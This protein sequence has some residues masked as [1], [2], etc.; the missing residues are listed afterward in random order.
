MDKLSP[1]DN[2]KLLN[3]VVYSCETK[4]PQSFQTFAFYLISWPLYC[5]IP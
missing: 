1:K 4:D 2:N 3:L 5:K